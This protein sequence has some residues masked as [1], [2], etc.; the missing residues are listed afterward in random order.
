MKLSKN[1]EFPVHVHF[2]RWNRFVFQ[3]VDLNGTI[4]LV[5]SS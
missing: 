3:S 4:D 2:D 1:N 5:H